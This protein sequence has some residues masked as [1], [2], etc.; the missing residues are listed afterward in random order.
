MRVAKTCISPSGHSYGVGSFTKRGGS[1]IIGG[2]GKAVGLALRTC[3]LL[4]ESTPSY[5]WTCI[6]GGVSFRWFKVQGSNGHVPSSVWSSFH[7]L[8]CVIARRLFCSSSAACHLRMLSTGL[9]LAC[10]RFVASLLLICPAVLFGLS[11]AFPG[12]P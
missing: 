7:L 1:S 12:S 3:A 5:R 10:R 6:H 9:S 4:D 11:F 8:R 2:L